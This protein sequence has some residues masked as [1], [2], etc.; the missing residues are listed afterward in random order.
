MI[1]SCGSSETTAESSRRHEV[2]NRSPSRI[3]AIVHSPPSPRRNVTN[4]P[5]LRDRIACCRQALVR[6]K[7]L[8][9]SSLYSTVTESCTTLPFLTSIMDSQSYGPTRNTMQQTSRSSQSPQSRTIARKFLCMNLLSCI[10]DTR[11]TIRNMIDTGFSNVFAWKPTPRLVRRDCHNRVGASR[12][13]A[14]ADHAN[15]N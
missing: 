10:V 15:F 3:A 12:S 4:S 7:R 11:A 8:C 13:R 1:E 5:P 6:P 9:T 2:S 14:T